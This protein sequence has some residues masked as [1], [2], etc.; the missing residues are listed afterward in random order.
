MGY[1]IE[2]S[3]NHGKAEDIA[4]AY[5]GKVHALPPDYDAET[6]K[7]NGIIVVMD[8]G[9]FEAAGFAYSPE[10]YASFLR[11][12]GRRRQY[13]TLPRDVAERASGF[14]R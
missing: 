12:D 7:G 13:V 9:P 3:K 10:E 5:S 14:A 1:Y 2:T 11:H 4:N 8:N 6:A